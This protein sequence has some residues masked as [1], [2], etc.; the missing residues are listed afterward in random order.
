MFY[1]LHNEVYNELNKEIA[2]QLLEQMKEVNMLKAKNLELDAILKEQADLLMVLENQ[3]IEFLTKIE[4]IEIVTH[5]YSD[6][7]NKLELSQAGLNYRLKSIYAD[8]SLID[9]VIKRL[10]DAQTRISEIIGLDR[11]YLIKIYQFLF[12]N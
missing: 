2:Q 12:K 1:E 10:G 6:R 8:L 5:T 7:L 3:K 4:K 9:S 11:K